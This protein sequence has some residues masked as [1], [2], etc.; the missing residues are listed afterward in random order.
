MFRKLCFEWYKL[1]NTLIGAFKNT[2]V[3]GIQAWAYISQPGSSY[4]I[5]MIEHMHQAEN[6]P[7]MSD[8]FPSFIKKVQD[9]YL[10]FADIHAVTSDTI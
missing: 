8:S 4:Q 2:F 10:G 3:L 5:I 9:H 1:E 7:T 6:H